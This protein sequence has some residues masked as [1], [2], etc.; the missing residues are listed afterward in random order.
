MLLWLP[1][2]TTD[3]PLAS[4][5][6]GVATGTKNRPVTEHRESSA[7]AILAFLHVDFRPSEKTQREEEERE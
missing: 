5:A 2:T 7:Y 4:Y 1:G 6:S 3:Q